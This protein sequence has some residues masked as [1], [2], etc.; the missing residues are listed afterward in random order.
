MTTANVPSI[1]FGEVRHARLRPAVNR[2]RYGAWFLRLPL[3][4][5]A[6]QPWRAR[7]LGLQRAA[8]MAVLD[9]D[10]GDGRPLLAW[11]DRSIVLRVVPAPLR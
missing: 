10:H 2:F 5:L 8:P 11:I 9:R 7:L 6:A 4:A 3:R 1:G